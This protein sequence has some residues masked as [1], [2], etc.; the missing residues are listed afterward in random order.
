[1]SRGQRVAPRRNIPAF[2]RSWESVRGPGGVLERR[3]DIWNFDQ[4]TAHASLISNATALDP[5]WQVEAR[6]IGASGASSCD[7]I[8]LIQA[9]WLACGRSGTLMSHRL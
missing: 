4:G 6:L 2:S 3:R 9:Q 5:S 8:S 1:M 7:K